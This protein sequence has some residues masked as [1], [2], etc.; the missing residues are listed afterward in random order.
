MTT[1][2]K[3]FGGDLGDIEAYYRCDLSE[4][5]A[6]IQEWNEE[7]KCWVG[8]QYQCADARHTNSGMVRLCH[9]LLADAV[10]VRRDEFTC[11][12]EEIDTFGYRVSDANSSDDCETFSDA[13]D[14]IAEWYEDVDQWATGEGDDDLHT[15]VLGAINGIEQPEDG[16]IDDLQTY[17][18]AIRSAVAEAM[19]GE[20]FAGHGNYAVSAPDRIG[21][22]LAVTEI[23][24]P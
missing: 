23:D 1:V 16:D 14:R 24:H 9:I 22:T 17:A 21:L 5:A 6:P 10:E 12:H 2:I 8:T 11:E 18:E 13:V 15:A 3:F 7:D 19:G 20:D 4:A